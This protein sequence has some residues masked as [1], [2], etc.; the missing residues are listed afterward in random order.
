LTGVLYVGQKNILFCLFFF[1]L[2]G[3]F[4]G[5]YFFWGNN[6]F[7]TPLPK[8]H[9]PLFS[10]RLIAMRY[11]RGAYGVSRRGHTRG[12]CANTH[13]RPTATSALPWQ[14]A[15]RPAPSEQRRLPLSLAPPPLS[16]PPLPPFALARPHERAAD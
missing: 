12:A 4:Q 2:P 1:F 15:E 7:G 5:G 11:G 3:P 13:N 10:G 9:P 16:P 6:L 14:L 8:T